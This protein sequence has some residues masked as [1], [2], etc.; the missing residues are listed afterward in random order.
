MQKKYIYKV[1]IK[2]SFSK[3]NVHML[4]EDNRHDIKMNNKDFKEVNFKTIG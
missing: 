1:R 3:T 4:G 2:I